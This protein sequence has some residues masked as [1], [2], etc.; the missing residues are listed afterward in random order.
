MRLGAKSLITWLRVYIPTERWN[1][2]W[3][4]APTLALLLLPIGAGLLQILSRLGIAGAPRATQA[5]IILSIPLGVLV[6][7]TILLSGD[8]AELPPV[9]LSRAKWLARFAVVGPLITV[10]AFFLVAKLT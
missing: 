9:V 8:A 10:L 5:L 1:A 4:L 3:L 6:G 7:S 2:A